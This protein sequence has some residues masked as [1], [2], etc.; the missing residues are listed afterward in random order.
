MSA[1]GTKPSE[2]SPAKRPR[3]RSGR[4]SQGNG[5]GVL[6]PAQLGT[7][8]SG[9]G[10]NAPGRWL[11]R[12]SCVRRCRERRISCASPTLP[13]VG[14][15][16]IE[17]SAKPPELPKSVALPETIETRFYRIRIDPDTGALTS[18]KLKP[19]GRE[20]LGGPANVIVA[21]RPKT[22]AGDPGDHILDRPERQTLAI[23]ASFGRK[24]P[25]F[26]DP[27][28]RPSRSSRNSTAADAWCGR[29][30]ST[31]IIRASISRP[32]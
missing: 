9:T 4:F 16:S 13:S 1:T 14:T 18:L 25:F 7:T 29:C 8:R 22:Q 3:R 15:V 10:E 19:S 6:Q 28:P 12:V 23:R 20:M 11:L 32:S 2:P 27:W 5:N 31:T 24:S 30:A 21:E 17:P 26:R